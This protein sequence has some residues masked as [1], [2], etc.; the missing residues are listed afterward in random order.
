MSLRHLVQVERYLLGRSH[1]PLAPRVD[2]ILLPLDRAGII[3]VA[4][5]PIWDLGIGLLNPA[6]QFFVESLLERFGWLH[7]GVCVRV[8]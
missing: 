6:Q 1:R 2:R 8:L 7:Y 4:V 5:L 3:K